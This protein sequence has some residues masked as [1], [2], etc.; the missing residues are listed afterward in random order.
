M[1]GY[2]VKVFHVHLGNSP[3]ILKPDRCLFVSVSI[4]TACRART[5]TAAVT[6]GP[7]R[8]SGGTPQPRSGGEP[9]FPHLFDLLIETT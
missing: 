1:F 5:R 2:S 4:N 8:C 3:A 9:A 7:A 6:E